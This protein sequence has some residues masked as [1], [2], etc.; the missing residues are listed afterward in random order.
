MLKFAFAVGVVAEWITGPE[1]T[2]GP[3]FAMAVTRALMA[4]LAAWMALE[5]LRAVVRAVQTLDDKA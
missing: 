2:S 3:A 1:V 4:T 5:V